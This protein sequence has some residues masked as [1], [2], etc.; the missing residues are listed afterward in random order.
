M[1]DSSQ[2]VKALGGDRV[3]P[4]ATPRPPK[5]RGFPVAIDG[6][7]LRGRRRAAR[8]TQTQVADQAGI[9]RAYMCELEKGTYN[10]GI[11]I[12]ESLASILGCEV[13]DLMKAKAA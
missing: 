4:P 1:D 2:P 3:L 11:D 9:S 8:L 12:V 10:P 13:S 5:R 6:V 7:A